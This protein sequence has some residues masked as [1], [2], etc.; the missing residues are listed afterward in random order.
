[1]LRGKTGKGRVYFC[2][3][4]RT[5]LR[6][7]WAIIGPSL[8]G[9]RMGAMLRL[10]RKVHPVLITPG[11]AFMAMHYLTMEDLPTYSTAVGVR[12]KFHRQL[13]RKGTSIVVNQL[14][15]P[16]SQQVSKVIACESQRVSGTY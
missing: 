11:L 16:A 9:L 10:V 15:A 13:N 6:W 4:P 7:S 8:P 12:K 2:L 5:A 14:S 1:M 3:L